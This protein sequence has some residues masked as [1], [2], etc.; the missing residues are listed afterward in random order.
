V[1]IAIHPN[2]AMETLIKLNQQ[3]PQIYFIYYYPT[4]NVNN[5]RYSDFSSFSHIVVGEKRAKDLAEI[6]SSLIKTYWKKIPYRKFGMTYDALSPRLKR[7]MNYIE[8]HELRDCSTNKI[9]AYL[10]ISSGYFSQEFK[11]ETELT[12]RTFMQRLI[13]HYEFLIFEKLDL[14]AKAASQILGYSELSSF[15]RSFKKRKG[16]PPSHQKNHRYLKQ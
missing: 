2:G 14:S 9:A 3:F 16:Y 7:V 6:L 13:D 8:T 4:L 5:F 1:L 12:F 11:R 10:D 15:S